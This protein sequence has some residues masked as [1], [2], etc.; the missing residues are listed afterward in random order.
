[1]ASGKKNRKA[2]KAAKR[3]YQP[4]AGPFRHPDGDR[5]RRGGPNVDQAIAHKHQFRELFGAPPLPPA[6]E[7]E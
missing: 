7:E 4:P 1:M 5:R 2:S 3:T 6:G